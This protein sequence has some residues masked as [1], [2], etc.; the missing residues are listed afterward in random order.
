MTMAN[1]LTNSVDT[2]SGLNNQLNMLGVFLQRPVVLFQL[3]AIAIAVILVFLIAQIIKSRLHKPLLKLLRKLPHR[4]NRGIR[5]CRNLIFP[6]LLIPVMNN[7]R[8]L[9]IWQDK[10]H[11]LIDLAIVLTGSYLIYRLALVVASQFVDPSVVNKYQNQFF[12]P[13][14]FLY[15]LSRTFGLALDIPQ[16][17]ALPIARIFGGNLTFGAIFLIT[18]GLYFWIVGSV[19]TAQI[20]GVLLSKVFGLS[21]S[22]KYATSLI[23]QYLL[24]GFGI[25]LILGSSGFNATAFAAIGGGL[26]VGLGFGLKEVFS[27]FVSGIWLLFEGSLRPGDLIYVSGDLC[28]VKKLGIRAATVEILRDSSERI[29]PNQTFFTSDVTT[30]TGSSRIVRRTL[31]VSASYAD[32]PEQVMALL[33][34]LA[35]E[36]PDVL[37]NPSPSVFFTEFADSSIN[38]QLRVYL[39][40]PLSASKTISHL[41]TT[42]WHAFRQAGFEMP[43]P[44]RD[45]YLRDGSHL[46]IERAKQQSNSTETPGSVEAG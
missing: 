2:V 22:A 28:E 1:T 31:Q 8:R 36:N 37:K 19:I 10:I 34:R 13:L 32:D 45:L 26:S 29:I 44:Q 30:Q 6:L 14:F 39:K 24:I 3:V 35:Q 7:L 38:Y 4:L 9:F 17:A 42:V 46:T 27:N 25:I 11:G 18:F 23:L 15:V 5:L 33:L 21:D 20:L 41:A 16:L 43:F 40:D 12:A